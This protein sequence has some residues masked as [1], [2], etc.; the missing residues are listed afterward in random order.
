[1]HNCLKSYPHQCNV[2][3]WSATCCTGVQRVAL[4][5]NFGQ[6]SPSAAGVRQRAPALNVFINVFVNAD[7]DLIINKEEEKMGV[8]KI[9]IGQIQTHW[10]RNRNPNKEHIHALAR[11]MNEDG[12]N[13]AFPL[14]VVE[15]GAEKELHLAAGHH[16]LAVASLTDL[17]YPNLPL[18]EVWAEITPGTMDD[19]ICLMQE[20]NFRNDPSVNSRL[21]LPLTRDE[22][23]AQCKALLMF[24]DV[25]RRSDRELA[26]DWGCH[27]NTVRGWREDVSAQ[28]VQIAAAAERATSPDEKQAVLE[29]FGISATRLED[30]VALIRSGERDVTRGGQTFTQKTVASE[31]KKQEVRKAAAKGYRDA[32]ENVV[33]ELE[34]HVNEKPTLNKANL[35]RRLYQAFDLNHAANASKWPL[36]TIRE[37]T[38]NMKNLLGELRHPDRQ[39]AA[40]R[41][42]AIFLVMLFLAYEISEQAGI[43]DKGWEDILNFGFMMHLSAAVTAGYYA[44]RNWR[45]RGFKPRSERKE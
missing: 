39:N 19:V 13:G 40:A 33:A 8:R 42:Y 7:L 20:N 36:E 23:A 28:I 45:K 43:G 4:E 35:K 34:L 26:K 29:E 9:P 44:L 16:R 12:F 1:M 38:A 27:Y 25:F 15:I 14:R 21:G 41:T 22:K 2:L 11:H 37:Q 6:F 32:H 10:E 18:A 17:T 24:P 3:H 31:D 30:M 5:E